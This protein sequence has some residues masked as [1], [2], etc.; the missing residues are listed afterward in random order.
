MI[1]GLLVSLSTLAHATGGSRQI[2]D[3]LVGANPYAG[4]Y[5]RYQ[6]RAARLAGSNSPG[7]ATI[8]NMGYA[9]GS[10]GGR[11]VRLPQ[12]GAPTTSGAAI[13]MMPIPSTR[14]SAGVPNHEIAV[15][16]LTHASPAELD[17]AVGPR[18]SGLLQQARRRGATTTTEQILAVPGVGPRTVGRLKG[19]AW[20]YTDR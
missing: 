7:W 5:A 11:L 18:K 14:P 1:V 17:A 16:A 3:G 19:L 15:W 9:R 13:Y 6:A 12:A 4:D 20:K 2:G 10:A 8:G